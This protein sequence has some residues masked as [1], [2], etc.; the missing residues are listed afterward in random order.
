MFQHLAALH[1]VG[2]PMKLLRCCTAFWARCTLAHRQWM[3]KPWPIRELNSAC[4]I[5]LHP[6]R[7]PFIDEMAE[8]AGLSRN[9]FVQ[10]FTSQA[11]KPPKLSGWRACALRYFRAF[12][13]QCAA[14]CEDLLFPDP[15]AFSKQFRQFHGYPPSQ[16]GQQAQCFGAFA[17]CLR[18]IFVPVACEP[19]LPMTAHGYRQL[20]IGEGCAHRDRHFTS[21]LSH[22]RRRRICS[23]Q[24]IHGR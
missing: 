5:G 1:A 7:L 19:W 8:I 11:G 17:N 15:F 16:V 10:L 21:M 4:A 23:L 13:C 22:F 20:V 3:L 12:R 18:F 14:S 6:V 2:N 9:Y 24:R